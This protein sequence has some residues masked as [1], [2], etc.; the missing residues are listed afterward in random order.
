VDNQIP[1]ASSAYLADA[2]L[3]DEV[4]RLITSDAK[5]LAQIAPLVSP[6]DFTAGQDRR[7]V[8]KIALE[9][10][11]R[12]RKP[13]G[14]LLGAELRNYARLEGLGKDKLSDLLKCL[15]RLESKDLSLSAELVIERLY[16]AKQSRRLEDAITKTLRL[17]EAGRLT[18]EGMAE[19]ARRSTVARPESRKTSAIYLGDLLRTEFRPRP[20]ILDPIIPGRGLVMVHG[21]P[22][23]GKSHIAL[24]MGIACAAGAR[25]LHW[26]AR[27]Q[28][29]VVYVAGEMSGAE[30]QALL[31]RLMPDIL[32]RA[33]GSEDGDDCYLITRALSMIIASEIEGGIPDLAGAQG[34]SWLEND[35]AVRNADVLILDNLSSLHRRGD[36]REQRGWTEMNEWLMHLKSNAV[37]KSV[38]LVHH[39]GKNL[40]QRGTSFREDILDTVLH[41]KAPPD[42]VHGAGVHTEIHVAKMRG[43]APGHAACEPFVAKLRQDH[44]GQGRVSWEFAPLAATNQIKAFSLFDEGMSVRNVM[45]ELK[46]SRASAFRF[47]KEHRR[48]EG[49]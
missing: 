49:D 13:I 47:Q 46:V 9:F 5:A 27:R 26:N 10:W 14:K 4:L 20:M 35:P 2:E 33:H 11:G 3:Q 34:R 23:L 12:F 39:D 18:S 22:G 29:R 43:Y 44:G 19:L 1:T 17:Y 40:T 42:Q 25:F 45:D 8:S 41:L 7:V 32:R 37:G 31:I 21:Y 36:E 38:I 15:A 16:E 24:G 28:S 6:E 30:N 48:R